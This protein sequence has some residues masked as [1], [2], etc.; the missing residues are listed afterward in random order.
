MR[1]NIVCSFAAVFAAF[2][3]FAAVFFAFALP[4]PA[5][6]DQPAGAMATIPVTQEQSVRGALEV[7]VESHRAI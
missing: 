7:I 6:A 5:T 1:S 4:V 3:Q 2:A